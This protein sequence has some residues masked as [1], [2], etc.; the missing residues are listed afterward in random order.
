MMELIRRRQQRVDE[1]AYRLAHAERNV[2]ENEA[3]AV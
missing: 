3:T 2:L 1:L